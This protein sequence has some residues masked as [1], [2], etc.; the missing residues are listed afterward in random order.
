MSEGKER[1]WNDAVAE[2]GT[3]NSFVRSSL[4]GTRFVTPGADAKPDAERSDRIFQ[5]IDFSD[6]VRSGDSPG[7]VTRETDFLSLEDSRKYEEF[8]TQ[9]QE[10][11]SGTVDV[12]PS[13]DISDDGNTNPSSA[14]NGKIRS[15]STVYGEPSIGE[16]KS[17][18]VLFLR[19]VHF[20]RVL[21]SPFQRIV[22][23]LGDSVLLLLPFLQIL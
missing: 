14:I 12:S 13:N 9:D 1:A 4:S 18:D 7:H 23:F 3:R 11:R 6:G 2:P 20:L 16:A 8:G 17:E 22:Q 19:Y 5:A 21:F 10:V 15:F